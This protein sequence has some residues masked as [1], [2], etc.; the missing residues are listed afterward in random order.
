MLPPARQDPNFLQTSLT[1]GDIHG[2]KIGTKGLGNFHTRVRREYKQTNITSD[3]FGAHP[4]SLKKS[5]E[6]IRQT[7]PLDPVYQ[8]PGRTEL[9]NINDA[10]GKPRIQNAA[11]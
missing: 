11:K 9:T 8:F 7:H 4:G 1:T 5:P 10:F 3:I 6:T 2:C